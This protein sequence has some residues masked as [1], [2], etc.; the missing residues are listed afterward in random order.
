MADDVIPLPPGGEQPPLDRGSILFIGTATTLIRCGGFTLLTDPNFLHAGDHAHL[1]YGLTSRRLTDPALEVDEL[2]PLDACLLSH[3]HGDHWDRIATERLPKDL[4]VVTTRHAA[5]ALTRRGF[6]RAHAL[7]T[8]E[9]V[10][11]T[12]GRRWLRIT[13][14]PG[15]HGPKLA[16]VL[17]PPVMGSMLEWGEGAH[18]P[19]FRLYVSGDTLVHDALR[20]IPERYPHVDAG[21]FHLGGT[22]V[23]GLLVTMDADQGV[24]AVRIVHPDVALPIHYD[25]YDVFRSPIEDF[26]RAAEGA[27]L[28]SRVVPLARG[29]RYEFE[30]RPPAAANEPA[31][32]TPIPRGGGR[33]G[34]DGTRFPPRPPGE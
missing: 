11:L 8:W 5:R 18:P 32:G 30:L 6:A 4:P 7:R 24:E 10:T 21:L 2:P 25:D 15:R 12:R 16:A 17:L 19:R 26:F 9:P 1:G 33:P 31:R 3:F 22:R 14:M 20:R 29:E 28:A 13:A 34:A 23:L 27:A